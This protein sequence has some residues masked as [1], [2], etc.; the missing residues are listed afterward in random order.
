MEDKEL[1]ELFE[2]KRTV[3]ANRRRQEELRKMLSATVAPKTR[4]L[5]PVWA[6][7][8]AASLALMLI[9][10]PMLF[11]SEAEEPLLVAEATPIPTPKAEPD[12]NIISSETSPVSRTSLT[13]KTS[14]IRVPRKTTTPKESILLAEAAEQQPEPV[15]INE[16]K[17]QP[18]E[19][20]RTEETIDEGPRIHRRTST[21]MV[22]SNCNINNV[23]SPRHD[24]HQF[25]A[26]ALGTGS[27]API[28]VKTIEF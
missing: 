15:I 11:R 7:S 17:P 25:L 26:D 6:F 1:Q 4:R 21:Q 16:P 13:S 22:C 10:L 18:V 5:W 19:T 23:P 12:T 3:E 14:S 9:T 24:F 28:T 8:A 2:A 20:K 27:S